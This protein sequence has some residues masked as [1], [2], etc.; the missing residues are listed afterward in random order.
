MPVWPPGLSL[1]T[2]TGSPNLSVQPLAGIPIQL[3]EIRWPGGTTSEVGPS[4]GFT[5]ALLSWVSWGHFVQPCW[6]SAGAQ[7][8]YQ[9]CFRPS[10]VL[11]ELSTSLLIA[12][13]QHH[14]LK[15]ETTVQSVLSIS[16]KQTSFFLFSLFTF[17]SFPPFLR[18]PPPIHPNTGWH[19]PEP[20][21]I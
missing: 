6:P 12:L 16:F 21:V 3:M 4:L 7:G 9:T 15:S 14:P 5:E 2:C 17:Y 19:L 20:S 8:S 13:M 10:C 18:P 11:G 1:S